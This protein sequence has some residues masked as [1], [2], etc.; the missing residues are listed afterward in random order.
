MGEALV[1]LAAVLFALGTVLQQKATL[2]TAAT[3][4][5]PRFG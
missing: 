5:K 1:I 3:E 4:G 2:S